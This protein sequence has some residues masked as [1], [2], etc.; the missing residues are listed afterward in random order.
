MAIIGHVGNNHTSI[1]G[2]K[3]HNSSI[4]SGLPGERT[5][6]WSMSDSGSVKSPSYEA[7][8]SM[9][10]GMT[11][12]HY[13]QKANWPHNGKGWA[14]LIFTSKNHPYRQWA[15][16]NHT[17]NNYGNYANIE[18]IIDTL[19]SDAD[20]W[21]SG[22]TMSSNTKYNIRL[23]CGSV[24]R[25][26]TDNC[27]VEHNNGGGEN[28][29][30]PCIG[31]DN[32]NHIWSDG[33]IW[34]NIDNTTNY[35]GLGNWISPVTSGGGTGD[36]LEIYYESYYPKQNDYIDFL[37]SAE[38]TDRP[39]TMTWT[40]STSG[41]SGGSLSYIARANDRFTT[42]NWSNHGRQHGGMGNGD[43]WMQV[44]LGAENAQI[45][46][47]SFVIGYPGRTH[48]SD[49]NYIKASN[50]NS[51]W[52][53]MA[54]WKHHPAGGSGTNTSA[55]GSGAGTV[56]DGYPGG[57]L[58][59]REGAH[60]YTN[61]RNNVEKWIPLRK[62]TTAYRYWR[63]GGTN[64][65]NQGNGYQLIMNWALLKRKD[66][67]DARGSW[68]QPFRSLQDADDAGVP[69]GHYWFINTLGYKE[70]CYIAMFEDGQ[71]TPS[72]SGSRWMLVSSNNGCSRRIPN[73]TSRNSNNY[74]LGC[75]GSWQFGVANPD[76]DYIIGHFIEDY[77]FAHAKIYGFG[78]N[79]GG[80]SGV[81]NNHSP[82]FK[83]NDREWLS[84]T[85]R[86]S[87][88][89]RNHTDGTYYPNPLGSRTSTNDCQK[90]TSWPNGMYNFSYAVVD[91]VRMDSGLNANSNQST[92]GGSGNAS[93]DPSG[94]CHI[95]HG[96]NES[97]N[98]CE[99]WYAGDSV[100]RDCQGYTTWVR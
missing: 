35:G 71:G 46:D 97:S 66:V 65:S 54:E 33:I 29:D 14:R 73:G 13:V 16:A 58:F 45:F 2:T 18:R 41:G 53:T 6:I 38:S 52:V 63:V 51:N 40:E 87:T 10:S 34:G 81:Q 89:N 74:R 22:N 57:Y 92:I 23:C 49:N 25:I 76:S 44:D 64:W 91:S 11:G 77:Q 20:N 95:G 98:Y 83:V 96:T 24:G 15:I 39:T 37:N 12:V 99:G 21:G 1:K 3:V 56:D 9:T 67:I 43:S 31:E 61:T 75:N 47:F 100:A 50:D 5:L 55:P 84:V 94:G 85:W 88:G 42:E 4:D 30:I 82:A 69:D 60:C 48:D 27:I 72:N 8:G 79:E 28:H 90:H 7:W 36:T 17:M 68:Q 59:F 19:F 32:G 78:Y 86:P 26:G 93:G 80:Y 70:H 62:T